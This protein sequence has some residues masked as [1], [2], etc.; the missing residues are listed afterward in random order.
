MAGRPEVFA[1][2]WCD[3]MLAAQS[4]V[5]THGWTVTDRSVLR[6]QVATA[7]SEDSAADPCS[8]NRRCTRNTCSR[9]FAQMVT[10][11]VN[12]HCAR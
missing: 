11:G 9:V 7:G 10:A 6:G 5:V 8:A 12:Q 4:S 3:W 2:G 1:C